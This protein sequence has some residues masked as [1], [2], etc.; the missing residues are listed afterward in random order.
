MALRIGILLLLAAA[1]PARAG[2]WPAYRGPTADGHAG[3]TGLPL[4]WSESRNVRWKRPIHDKG[5]SSPV[6]WGNQVW[7]STARD[8]GK[9]MFVICV[10]RET[11]RI[12]YDRK[13]FDIANPRSIEQY[14]SYAS[15]SPVIE[16]GRVYVHFGSYGTACL[17]TDTAEIR[18]QRRDLPCNHYRGPGSSPILFGDL[19][20]FHMDGSD[21]QYVVALNKFDGETVWKTNRSTDFNDFGPDGKPVSDG[22]FRK[23]FNTPIMIETGGRAQLISPAAKAAFAYD[24]YSGEEL[25]TVRHR[26]HSS[27]PRTLFGHG[28]VFISTGFGK[29]E[30]LAVRP[31]GRGD[32][33][34]THVA[35]RF[36]KNMPRMPSSVLIDGLIYT[37]S[38]NGIVSCLEAKSGERF[39]RQR[40][41][42][43]YSAS[44]VHSDGRI[45]A[46]SREGRTTVFRPGRTFEKLGESKLDDGFRASAAI[47]G[48]AFYLR[49]LTHLYRIEEETK[50][51]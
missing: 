5:W 25:W 3:G 20:I 29:T 6:V 4:L 23:A 10:D 11:G 17:D 30:L 8:D 44:L 18:W 14:N 38:D 51:D 28:M 1:S 37:C 32:V 24:P 19:L 35:W 21:H 26:E 22:D 41:G 9:Q 7:L 13:L 33:T 27:A 31:D 39:W 43:E 46:F 48:K 12:V 42:G 45:Y 47:A 2:N 40:I 36:G 34:D 15:P 49:T 16:A 50:S